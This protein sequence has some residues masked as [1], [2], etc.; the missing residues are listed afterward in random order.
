MTL[1]G[2]GAYAHFI[3]AVVGHMV[4]R[5]EFYTAYTPYQAEISQGILQAIYEY[6]TMIAHL[7]GTEIA[8]ASMYDGASATA[9][10]AVLCVKMSNRSGIV[11]A[12]SV[13]P[14]YRQVLKTYAWANGYTLTEIP[15]APSGQLD[16]TVL[17]KAL[18]K[19]VAAVVVQSPNF[20][21]C[22]EDLTPVAEAAHQNGTL[23]I[24]GFTDGTSLGVLKPAGESGADL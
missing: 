11:V 19:S 4:G 24:A 8:N 2:A 15:Y 12:R 16:L 13:H 14:Q 6:Q 10:A 7:T 9:E 17:A 18:D 22:I 3:P 20:F 21:G 23:L 5:A 1:T